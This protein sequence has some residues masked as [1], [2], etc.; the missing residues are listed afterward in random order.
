MP[1]SPGM[2]LC[3]LC[4]RV[5]DGGEQLEIG[6]GKHIHGV[7]S[8]KSRVLYVLNMMVWV[9]RMRLP[10]LLLTFAVNLK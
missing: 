1:L 9:D 7:I 4:V 3:W 5:T 10:S 2:P 8:T 6:L